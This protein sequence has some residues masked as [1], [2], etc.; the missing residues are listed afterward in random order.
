MRLA[1]ET[2]DA[3]LIRRRWF[4]RPLIPPRTATAAEQSCEMRSQHPRCA[5]P[6]DKLKRE[7][8]CQ[9]SCGHWA[10]SPSSTQPTAMLL[11]NVAA[12]LRVSF[13]TIFFDM[14]TA[15]ILRDQTSDVNFTGHTGELPPKDG[16][17]M[18]MAGPLLGCLHAVLRN[19]TASERR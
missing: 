11:K 9:L 4:S 7:N 3:M 10:I 1:R 8:V 6:I 18:C 17:A 19:S 16:D 13:F 2:N 12:N 15:L 5:L 14:T